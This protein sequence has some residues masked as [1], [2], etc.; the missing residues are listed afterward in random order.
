[1]ISYFIPESTQFSATKRISDKFIFSVNFF[2]VPPYTTITQFTAQ[3]KIKILT[4]ILPPLKFYQPVFPVGSTRN[5][6]I[7][8]ICTPDWAESP[9]STQEIC[10]PLYD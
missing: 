2:F 3:T 1:M 4:E 5:T 10:R 9:V 6:F 7:A 8:G